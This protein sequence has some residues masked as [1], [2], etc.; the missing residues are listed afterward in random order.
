MTYYQD[1]DLRA[2]VEGLTGDAAALELSKEAKSVSRTF[3]VFLSHSVR[4]ALLILGLRKLLEKE[5]LTVY[6]DWIEDK[7]LACLMDYFSQIRMLARTMP[8]R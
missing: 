4:D 5:G 6:V 8:A 2:H 7:D 3:D 1:S